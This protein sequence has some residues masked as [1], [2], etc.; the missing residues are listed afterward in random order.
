MN[1]K[2]KLQ[3]LS[4][5]LLSG[6]QMTDETPPGCTGVPVLVDIFMNLNMRQQ[7]QEFNTTVAYL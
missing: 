7:K 2:I 6:H 4:S 5:D 1:E 3:W